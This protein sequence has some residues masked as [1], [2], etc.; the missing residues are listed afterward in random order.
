VGAGI[1]PAGA[2]AAVGSM[3]AGGAPAGAGGV[4]PTAGG[5]P[6][7]P[8]G[9]CAAAGNA[10]ASTSPTNAALPHRAPR[11]GAEIARPRGR[12]K[13]DGVACDNRAVRFVALAVMATACVD[14][15]GLPRRDAGADAAHEPRDAADERFDAASAS[16]ACSPDCEGE[17]AGDA[18]TEPVEGPARYPLDRTLS[19]I[20]PWVAERLRATLGAGLGEDVFAKVGDS[21]TVSTAFLH[22][23]AGAGVELGAHD[24]L[25]PTLEHFLAGRAGDTTP[26]DRE[27]LAATVGWSAFAPLEGDPSP[28]QRELDAIEPAFAIVMF[29]TNDVGWRHPVDYGEDM[30]EIADVLLA[31]GVIPLF[32][33]IPPRDDDL[34]ADA[35][36]PFI[37]AVVRGLAE[38]RQVPFMDLERELRALPS[39]G[40]GGD[41]VHLDR[42]PDGACVLTYPGLEHGYN[43]RNLLA[44][45][46]LDRVRAVVLDGALAPDPPEP[47]APGDGTTAAPF[48]LAA[49]TASALATTAGAP[50]SDLATYT[51]CGAAQDES[52]PEVVYELALDV[53][54]TLHAVVIDQGETDVDLHLLGGAVLE[55]ACLARHDRELVEELDAGT[56]YLVLDTYVPADGVAR[57]GEYL[58][59]VTAD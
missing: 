27:S 32:S 17:D 49:G 8:G 23:F 6:G 2:G 36:V 42:D 25:E 57:A 21:I 40:L 41:G 58:L 10:I 14:D 48:V 55:D 15:A 46:T 11:I 19:P 35:R 34:E 30:M 38:G 1:A 5:A 3:G 29:G 44:L 52:G 20:T 18:G 54:A 13:R 22:C 39:H 33:S 31:R 43:W 4:V 28:L 59:V 16:D 12:V 7:S 53:P 56:Y 37:N 9:C 47:R 26:F 24:A 51:G 50:Q 45:Q